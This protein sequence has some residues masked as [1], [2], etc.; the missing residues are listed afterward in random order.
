MN[1]EN[2]HSPSPL[3]FHFRDRYLM[4]LKK[5]HQTPPFLLK[6]KNRFVIKIKTKE[7]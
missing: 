3:D 1:K 7:E 6:Q 2:L 5:T 4:T